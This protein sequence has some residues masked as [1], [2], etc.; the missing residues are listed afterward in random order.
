MFSFQVFEAAMRWL[1]HATDERS[2][3]IYKV[4][5]HIRLALIDEHYFYDEVKNNAILQV[6]IHLFTI[7]ASNN[8]T[9]LKF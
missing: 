6:R 4:F 1:L 7:F 5:V 8:N 2:E 9:L 3:F